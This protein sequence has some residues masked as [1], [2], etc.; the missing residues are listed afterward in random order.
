MVYDFKITMHSMVLQIAI[1][2]NV[3]FGMKKDQKLSLDGSIWKF[4][5][6]FC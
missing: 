3:L 5:T 1:G 6:I 2:T 4:K